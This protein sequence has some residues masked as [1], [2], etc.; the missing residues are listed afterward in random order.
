MPI[1]ATKTVPEHQEQITIRRMIIDFDAQVYI[2]QGED[3]GKTYEPTQAEWNYVKT[4]IEGKLNSIPQL[5]DVVIDD[6]DPAKH[7]NPGTWH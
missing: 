5:S 6:Y 7:P 2:F 1:T 4:G 3:L